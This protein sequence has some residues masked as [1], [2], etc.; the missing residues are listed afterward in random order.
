VLTDDAP[1]SAD[2]DRSDAVR[3]DPEVDGIAALRLRGDI[4]LINARLV[5][6]QAQDALGTHS[7]IVLDLSD[8]TFVDSS[9]IHALLRVSAAADR[10]GCI[11]VLQLGSATTVER[12][13]EIAGIARV[14]PRVKSREEAIETIRRLAATVT[15]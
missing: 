3:L 1:P 8:A 14:I 11:T 4:D 15:H 5:L 13:I 12:A 6:E 2:E 10:E 9:A 7:H